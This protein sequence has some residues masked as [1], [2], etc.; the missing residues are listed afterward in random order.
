MLSAVA[1]S[2]H[3]FW[4]MY[5]PVNMYCDPGISCIVIVMYHV[6]ISVQLVSYAV[7]CKNAI[8][9]ALVD[10]QHRQILRQL[11]LVRKFLWK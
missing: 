10:L 5:C 6:L 3:P 11:P 7:S 1:C 9:A 8:R 2:E 4:A